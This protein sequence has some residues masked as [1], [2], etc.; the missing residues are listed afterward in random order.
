MIS[1]ETARPVSRDL[2]KSVL[3]SFVTGVSVVTARDGDIS[4]GVTV[5]A[6]SSVSLD[7][8][9]LSVGLNRSLY[10]ATV[11]QREG[12]FAVNFLT[13]GQAALAGHFAA[14]REK[15]FLD[16]PHRHGINMIPILHEN[17]AHAECRVF[18]MEEIG[19]HYVVFGE[20]IGGS[21]TPVAP[22]TYFKRE[23]GTF[24]AEGRTA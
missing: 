17:L 14:S 7:P 2:F 5:T 9:I 12:Y 22:L 4:V 3:G 10:T 8:P 19:D 23:F 13:E 6:V 15:K 24:A 16:V 21:A 18:R 11:V 20:V 1:S